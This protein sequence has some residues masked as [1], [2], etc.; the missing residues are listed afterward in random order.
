MPQDPDADARGY[1][2]EINEET[3]TWMCMQQTNSESSFNQ[4]LEQ[5]T[6][7]NV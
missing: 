2:W 7:L 3:C 4:C 6:N 5:C 1:S